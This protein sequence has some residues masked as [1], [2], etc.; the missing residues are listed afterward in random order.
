MKSKKKCSKCGEVKPLTEFYRRHEARDGLRSDCCSCV[1]VR[2][3]QYHEE[4]R[5][6]DNA[7]RH[8]WHVANRDRELAR[9]RQR[10]VTNRAQ[11]NT[12]NREWRE[13]NRERHI[14]LCHEWHWAN[15]TSV[16]GRQ[17][18][19]R[20]SVRGVAAKLR[21]N[22]GLN[23]AD[24][25]RWAAILLDDF[26]SCAICGIP[27]HKLI[28]L[29]TW[30]IGGRRHNSRRLSL[31]HVTPGVND[32]NYRPLCYSCNTLRGA[33]VLSD[34]EVLLKMRGWYMALFPLRKLW[35]LHSR[36]VD[37]VCT[38]G[39]AHR[40]EAMRRKIEALRPDERSDD[41]WPG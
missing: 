28:R 30:E 41:W 38:G 29:G 8:E 31:D 25:E 1:K 17:R 18:A 11:D 37:G 2:Q 23:K 39:R 3:R 10:H 5:E 40:S 20:A 35:W 24:S 6:R 9:M 36:V 26:T 22:C 7:R 16:L 32:G 15:R 33:A 27:R 14:A 4:N 12:R 13:A 21:A 19:Y 34:G